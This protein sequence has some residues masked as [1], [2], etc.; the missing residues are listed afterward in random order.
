MLFNSYEFIF[1]FFPLVMLGFYLV[2]ARSIFAA[3][4]F[5]GLASLFFYGWWSVQAVPLLLGSIV[6]NYW[7]SQHLVPGSTDERRRS[8]LLTFSVATNLV[9]LGIFKYADFFID[10][11]NVGLTAS[12]L[13][14]FTPLKLLL[15]IGISFYTFTQIAFLVDCWKG[16]VKETSFVHYLLFVTYFPHLVAGPVLHHAQMMPQFVRA[17]TYRLDAQN[18]AIGLGTFTI[19]LSKKLLIADPLGQYA[20]VVFG[21]AHAGRSLDFVTAWLGTFAYAFQIYFDFSGYSDMAIGLSLCLGITL[22]LNFLSPYKATSIVDF[23]RRWHIS[24]SNFLR[25]YLYIPLGGGRSGKF[26]RYANLVI[27]MLLGGLWHGAAW[28]FVLWGLAHGFFLVVTHLWRHWRPEPE[29]KSVPGIVVGWALTFTCVCL[30]WVLFRAASFGDA[31]AF[32]KGMLGLNG[33]GGVPFSGL[34]VP[35]REQ[36]FFRILALAWAICVFAPSTDALA[37]MAA[38]ARAWTGLKLAAVAGSAAGFAVLLGAGISRLGQHS[39]FLYT[40]F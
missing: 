35:Y 18:I 5:L 34:P 14:T 29:R 11:V 20:D 32:Y 21:A 23:W 30:A 3:S 7:I 17:S 15:P 16:K 4:G 12:G 25:D 26:R 38:T 36:E 39:P 40:Q 37:R 22:P 19:G 9:V 6:F 31:M 10:N 1:L 13:P 8:R 33:W 2:G 27:T 24:L 28:T